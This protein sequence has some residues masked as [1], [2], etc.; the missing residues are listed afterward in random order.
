[1]GIPSEDCGR[2]DLQRMGIRRGGS[3]KIRT[4]SVKL[5]GRSCDK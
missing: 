5:G 3:A 2:F 1:M 4:F